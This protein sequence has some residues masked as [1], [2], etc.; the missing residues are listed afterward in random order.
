MRTLYGVTGF[1]RTLTEAAKDEDSRGVSRLPP[2]T[3][4][5]ADQVAKCPPAVKVPSDEW[6]PRRLSQLGIPYIPRDGT[7]EKAKLTSGTS[8]VAS[9]DRSAESDS[10]LSSDPAESSGRSDSKARRPPGKEFAS[11]SEGPTSASATRGRQEKKATSRWDSEYDRDAARSEP[12]RRSPQ[13]PEFLVQT[14]LQAGATSPFSVHSATSDE[15]R[16][17]EESEKRDEAEPRVQHGMAAVASSVARTTGSKH[18]RPHRVDD[19]QAFDFFGLNT[20]E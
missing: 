4:P 11:K 2:T 18:Q 3:T 20:L 15:K 16:P 13:G 7:K 10:E 8:G 14:A 1:S 5:N 12:E 9:G 17:H 6:L 19:R